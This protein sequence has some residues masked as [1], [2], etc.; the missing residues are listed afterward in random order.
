MSA[1]LEFLKV[2]VF[3]LVEGFTEWLPIS[4]T[5]HLIL[6]ENIINLNASENFMNVFRVMIQLGAI[7]AVLVVYGLKDTL[8][9]DWTVWAATIAGC[10]SVMALHAWKHNTILSVFAGTEVYIALLYLL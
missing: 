9:A 8:S 4:S 5:G 3:G 1:V 10:G 6:V 7:M 2:V